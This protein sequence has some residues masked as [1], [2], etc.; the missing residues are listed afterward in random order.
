MT[1]NKFKILVN[2]NNR[3]LVIPIETNEDYLNQLN[4]I[5]AFDDQIVKRVINESVMVICP[6]DG[7]IPV[8][9]AALP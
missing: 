4:N 5:D 1:A 3:E 2:D 7:G 6:G 9:P 8:N